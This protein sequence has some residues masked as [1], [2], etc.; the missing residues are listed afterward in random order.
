MVGRRMITE[1]DVRQRLRTNLRALRM[2]RSLA[3]KEAAARAK[4]NVRHWQ[5]IESGEVNVTLQTLARLG[6]ALEIDP[7]DLIA[8]PPIVPSK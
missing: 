2:T 8:D 3:V 6:A 4:M 7:A 5:K 1:E